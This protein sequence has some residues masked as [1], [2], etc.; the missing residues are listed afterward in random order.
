MG[1]QLPGRPDLDE[2]AFAKHRNAVAERVGN[3]FT[4]ALKDAGFSHKP[5]PIYAHALIG[6]VTFVG[7]W[8]M[9]TRKPSIEVVASHIAALSWMGLRNL[10][11][12]PQPI[13]ADIRQRQ[14]Q[15]APA[16]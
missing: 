3:V 16:K 5:A 12:K 6:M 1:Q 2:R 11:Q 7:Q 14:E 8:W 13:R 9:A 10:P 4:Q 15:A